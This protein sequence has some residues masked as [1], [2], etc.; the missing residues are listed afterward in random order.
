MPEVSRKNEL[1]SEGMASK[2]NKR[3]MEFMCGG[4]GGVFIN[5]LFSFTPS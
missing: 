4:R 3:A 5:N 1:V 2:A